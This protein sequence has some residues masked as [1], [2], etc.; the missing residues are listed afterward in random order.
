MHADALPNW[1]REPSMTINGHPLSV[2]QS[3]AVRVAVSSF[4]MELNDP[5]TA[6]SWNGDE[7]GQ[8][9]RQG[10]LDRL[11]EVLKYMH[12]SERART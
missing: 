9:I 3:L 4:F 11:G 12:E 1:P 7:T 10:Y 2:G 5:E 8:G 6:A